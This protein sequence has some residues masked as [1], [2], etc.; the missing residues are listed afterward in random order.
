MGNELSIRNYNYK[1]CTGLYRCDK[2]LRPYVRTNQ[3]GTAARG[4][5]EAEKT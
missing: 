5:S 4:V 3:E 2:L 1:R